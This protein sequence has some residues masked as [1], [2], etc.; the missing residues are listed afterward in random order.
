MR[1]STRTFEQSIDTR[2][3]AATSVVLRY[4]RALRFDGGE[5]DRFQD[6]LGRTT[7][8]EG[9]RLFPLLE[10]RGVAMDVLD[11]S[12]RMHTGTL[13]SIDGCVT[14]ARCLLEGIRRIVFESGGNTA[15]AL[16]A[17]ARRAGIEAYSLVPE[18]NLS[19][20]DSGIYSGGTIH[21]IAVED[22]ASVRG[23]AERFE[24]LYAVTRVPRVGWRLSASE[25]IGCYI[26]EQLIAG[27]RWTHIVQPIS[28]AFG[29]IGIYRVL[30]RCGLECLPRFVGVQ[31][32]PNCAMV[33]AMEAGTPE[34][35]PDSFRSTS[36]LLSRVM[37]DA[38]PQRYGTFESLRNLLRISR[39]HLATVDRREFEHALS[40]QFGSGEGL[41]A[42][43]SRNGVEITCLDGEVVE[44][45]GVMGLAGALKQIEA[46]AIPPGSRV[47]CCLTG[48]TATPDGRAV[49]EFRIRD[50]SA[51]EGLP[52]HPGNGRA[53]V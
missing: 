9:V 5:E 53:S 51:L 21:L 33:R 20:L 6:L 34:V 26:L 27:P 50:L 49:P 22:V 52:I 36:D 2:H 32:A 46:G 25:F 11:E 35:R 40:T 14:T 8:A 13:K 10:Y 45:T 17:Y 38:T 19:L 12:S 18:E 23:S 4:R 31:Q 43:L 48:G 39:G 1:P 41:L 29:P 24:R 16:A 3:D 42:L 47:L 28:A 44:K 7:I 30:E 15:T 37:Y